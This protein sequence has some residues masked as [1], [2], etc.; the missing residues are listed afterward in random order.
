MKF[1]ARAPSELRKHAALFWPRELAAKQQ[2]TN[3]IPQL[4]LTQD[5]FI[6]IL[7]V[8]DSNPVAW[9]GACVTRLEDNKKR[10]NFP[11]QPECWSNRH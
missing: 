7:T 2:I 1:Y 6:S 10:F 9:K 11:D 8:A 4:I 3:I 5:Q